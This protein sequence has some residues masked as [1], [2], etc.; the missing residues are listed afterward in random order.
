MAPTLTT[1]D[2]FSDV[3]LARI[4][5][6]AR[7]I[8]P[9]FLSTPQFFDASLSAAL[10]RQV[11]VKVE[12]ANPVRSFK[13]RGADFLMQQLKPGQRVVCPSTGNFGQAIA[14]AGRRRGVE[15]HVFVPVG[16]NPLKVARIEAF[17]A[18]I[19]RAVVS[20][21]EDPN[22]TRWSGKSLSSGQ[23]A[24]IYGFTDLDGSQP[25]AW[26]YLVEVQDAGKPAD[27]TGYR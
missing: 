6:A 22:V 12:T 5:L 17:G 9:A 24:T 26:R 7:T 16:S 25:D 4:E 11:L 21:A 18:R 13:G 15:V 1:F 2:T 8:D 20:L 23:L 10:N 19:G 3:R 14:Y 27:V